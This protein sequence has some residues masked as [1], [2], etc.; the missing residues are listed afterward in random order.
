MDIR[1]GYSF[2][3]AHLGMNPLNGEALFGV[4]AQFRHHRI[5]VLHHGLRSA[6]CITYW[7]AQRLRTMAD[8]TN[9]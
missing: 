8:V 9:H 7:T 6:D 5:R 3:A 1:S 2:R 4:L